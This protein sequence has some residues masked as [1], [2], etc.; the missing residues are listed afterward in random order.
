[1][2]SEKH[3]MMVG[4][5]VVAVLLGAL[6]LSYGGHTIA[7]RTE[8]GYYRLNATFNRVDGL[9]E[10]DE[11][12]LGGIKVGTVAEMK[13][14]PHFRAVLGLRI[15][16]GLKLPRDSSAS[17]QTAGLFGPKYIVLE[18]GGDDVNFKPGDKIIYTQEA[19]IVSELLNLIISQGQAAR[20]EAAETKN[21]KAGGFMPKVE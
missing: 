4:G 21:D 8:S 20:G 3:E 13:L 15:Q 14:D 18:P 1:M 9:L 6:L 11:V 10:G 7:K 19:T 5:G 16:D 12:R 2:A 17:I